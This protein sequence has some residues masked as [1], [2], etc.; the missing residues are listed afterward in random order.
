MTEVLVSVG[1]DAALKKIEDALKHQAT[2]R[3]A[4]VREAVSSMKP[5][6][7]GLDTLKSAGMSPHDLVGAQTPTIIVGSTYLQRSFG[8]FFAAA[9]SCPSLRHA[10]ALDS[11]LSRT[12]LGGFFQKLEG[13]HQPKLESYLQADGVIKAVSLTD[14]TKRESALATVATTGREAGLS[15]RVVAMLVTVADELITNA[16][17]DAPTD[18]MGEFTHAHRSRA[19]MVSL[20]KG[21]VIEVSIGFDKNHLGISVADPFGSLRSQTVVDYLAKCYRR[22]QDQVDRKEGGAGLGLFYVFES[23]S[24]L[25][26]DLLPKKKTTLISLIPV[27]GSYR[28]TIRASKSICVFEAPQPDSR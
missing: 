10:V 18:E 28:T 2:I 27:A 22:G 17:Y 8:V 6:I 13:H 14:S 25:V 9:S 4:E 16:L 1:D 11:P 19:S 7:I 26:V 24:A 12:L 23:S 5:R 20:P 21:R 3:R 15:R